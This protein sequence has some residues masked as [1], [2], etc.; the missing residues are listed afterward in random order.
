MCGRFIVIDSVEAIEKRFNAEARAIQLEINYNL[1]PG[2]MAPVITSDEP[3]RVRLS[4]FGLNPSW[5]KKPMMLINARA[6]GDHN[7]DDDPNFKG[8]KGIIEKPSFRKPIRSQR[9]LVIA[10]AFIEGPKDI[11]LSKPYLIYMQNKQRPFAMAG[12]WDTWMNDS[13]SEFIH[14]FAIITTTANSLLQKI[15]HH[16]MPVI[17]HPADERAWLNPDTNLTN[18][19]GMLAP[20]EAELMNAYPIGPEI[21]NPRVNDK[22]LLAPIGERLQ[23]EFEYKT[24]QKFIER[25]FGHGKARDVREDI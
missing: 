23:A 17:I 9:C 4:R 10:S 24:T 19:T 13:K 6:E 8:A 2:Q 16:R 12:I 7:P 21:K 14:S 1:G 20:Y 15:G 5:A 11:G 18:I 3:G 22:S 25:G